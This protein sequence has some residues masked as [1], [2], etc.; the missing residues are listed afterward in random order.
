MPAD[1]R[2]TCALSMAAASFLAAG[3]A[4]AASPVAGFGPA[5]SGDA[6][7]QASMSSLTRAVS[8]QN[9]PFGDVYQ[10][11]LVTPAPEMR[12]E[13]VA[14]QSASVDKLDLGPDIFNDQSLNASARSLHTMLAWRATPEGDAYAFALKQLEP[15]ADF[16]AVAL[17]SVPV[18][19]IEEE[20]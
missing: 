7:L 13:N 6:S 16:E 2:K 4:F 9:S 17:A 14:I 20:Q 11:A 19:G 18:G 10:L 5:V 15:T 8:W 12:F 1:I 3:A